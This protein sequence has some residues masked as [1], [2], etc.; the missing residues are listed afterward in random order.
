MAFEG[1]ESSCDPIYQDSTK[2]KRLKRRGEKRHQCRLLPAL[3]EAI[4]A[5]KSVA[6]NRKSDACNLLSADA[7]AVQ[8]N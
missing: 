6:L 1:M 3:Y 8:T 5:N 2:V 7:G 4:S